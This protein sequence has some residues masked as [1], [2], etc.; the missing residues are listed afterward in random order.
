M[1][2]QLYVVPGFAVFFLDYCMW[3]F[4]LLVITLPLRS[5]LIYAGRTSTQKIYYFLMF[6]MDS[7]L[8]HLREVIMFNQL[9]RE[10]FSQMSQTISIN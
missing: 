8:V 1:I 5:Q 7:V 2:Y 4:F 6:Y 3:C 10:F 9:F